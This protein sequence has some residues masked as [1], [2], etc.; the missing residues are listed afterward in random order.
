MHLLKGY[1]GGI[2]SNHVADQSGIGKAMRDVELGPNLVGHGVADAQEGIGK[3]HAGDCRS[4]VH[5]KMEDKKVSLLPQPYMHI[6]H[7]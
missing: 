5:L 6:I 1:V 4:I 2:V 3:S 7:E